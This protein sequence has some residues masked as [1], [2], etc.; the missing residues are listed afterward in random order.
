MGNVQPFVETW[1][2]TAPSDVNEDSPLWASLAGVTQAWA[3]C[4]FIALS[5]SRCHP[6]ADL[7]GP[8]TS[9]GQWDLLSWDPDSLTGQCEG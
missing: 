8:Q 9:A 6:D 7:G 4:P 3:G 5:G 2:L 1:N